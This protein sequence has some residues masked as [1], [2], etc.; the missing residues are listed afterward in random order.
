ILVGIGETLRD[1]AESL[2]ALRDAHERHGHVQ[3]VIVQ[4]FRAKPQTAMR[5]AP[6]AA[7]HEYI[8]AVAV[9]RLVFGPRMR[10]QVPP[11]LSDRSE[12]ELLARAGADAWGGVSPLTADHVNPDRPW[13]HLGE[14]ADRTAELGFTLR[15]R[16]T[17]HPEYV[18]EPAIW[19]DPAM[20]APVAALA[21]PDGLAASGSLPSSSRFLSARST[22]AGS[23]RGSTRR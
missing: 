13:P 2:V 18:R 23:D 11:T 15:E 1:R 4:N 17:A 7:L 16:L 5:G 9:A 10:I 22:P 3:E 19:L 6:D 12:L 21:G 20:R 8:A 14:L